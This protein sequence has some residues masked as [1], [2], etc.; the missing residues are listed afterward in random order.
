MLH[1]DIVVLGILLGVAHSFFHLKFNFKQFINYGA[2]LFWCEIGCVS[3][4]I[5]DLLSSLARNV[6][7]GCGWHTN[8]YSIY[9]FDMFTFFIADPSRNQNEDSTDFHLCRWIH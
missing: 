1:L 8:Y 2:V 3:L 6:V 5:C 9:H 4:L 7:H